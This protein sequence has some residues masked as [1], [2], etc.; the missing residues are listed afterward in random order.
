[1]LIRVVYIPP[2]IYTALLSIGETAMVLFHD[3]P[4]SYISTTISRNYI[5]LPIFLDLDINRRWWCLGLYLSKSGSFM[6]NILQFPW[7]QYLMAQYTEFEKDLE[8]NKCS[9]VFAL[10]RTTSLLCHVFQDFCYSYM[11]ITN[12]LDFL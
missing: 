9:F 11:S 4:D 10:Y 3:F 5:K 2:N 12:A 1:M 7:Y 6:L 8:Q